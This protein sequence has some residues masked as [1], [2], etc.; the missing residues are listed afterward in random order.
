VSLVLRKIRKSKWYKSESVPWL[1]AEDL[2]SDALV[3]L[4]TKGNKLSVYLVNDDHSNLDQI[5]T[6][7]S[8]NCDYISD[9]EYAIFDKSELIRIGIEMDNTEGDTADLLVNSWHYDLI[10]LSAAKIMALASIISNLSKRE[11][12]LSKRVL[13]MVVKAIASGQLDRA[14]LRLKAE[15]I[16]KIDE[17]IITGNYDQ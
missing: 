3:D 11:R 13:K 9:F 7:L 6:A 15:L 8:A 4:A 10:E 12:V 17:L 1:A 5:I 16:A 14:K 2:Q